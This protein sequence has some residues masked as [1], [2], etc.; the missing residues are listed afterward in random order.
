MPN[1]KSAKKALRASARKRTYN[2]LKKVKIK[3]AYKSL[4][5]NL[6]N[7]PANAAQSLS[8]VFSALDKAVKTNYITKHR[9][10]RKKSRATA[11]FKRL[12]ETSVTPA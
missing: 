8:A 7:E 2:Q 11:M 3:S 5:K 10:A 4:R 12:T 9:A 1:T 6:A